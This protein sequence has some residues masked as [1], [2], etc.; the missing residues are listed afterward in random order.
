L[1]WFE[2]NQTYLNPAAHRSALS[3]S[4]PCQ[5]VPPRAGHTG[6]PPSLSS[7]PLL[8][9]PTPRA[10]HLPASRLSFSL[11]GASCAHRS[12]RAGAAF[13]LCPT[14]WLDPPLPLP[15]HTTKPDPSL[16]L[17]LFF[18]RGPFPLLPCGAAPSSPRPHRPRARFG[19]YRAVGAIHIAPTAASASSVHATTR[20]A[21]EPRCRHGAEPPRHLLLTPRL[22]K[23]SPPPRSCPGPAPEHVRAQGAILGPPRPAWGIRRPHHRCAGAF[24]PPSPSPRVSRQ[25]LWT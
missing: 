22:S 10:A 21:A 23:A 18:P 11:L 3:P 13:T 4:S 6:H 15:P 17:L 2:I 8:L 14:P 7:L 20:R 9:G 16:S 19:L 24:P 25:L 5:R 1:N 12:S